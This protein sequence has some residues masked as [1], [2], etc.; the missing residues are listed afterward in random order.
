GGHGDT[1][2]P[3]AVPDGLG[4][5]PLPDAN[6]TEVRCVHGGSISSVDDPVPGVRGLCFV[7]VTFTAAIVLD[8]SRFYSPQH[9]LNITLLQCVLMGLS[10]RGIGARVHVNVVF[11]MLDSGDLEFRG[12]FGASSQLLVAGCRL[13]SRSGCAIYFP[14]FSFG[15]NSTLQLLGNLIEG[16]N[17]AV[18]FV[19]TVV[20]DGG[21]IV[22]KGNTL[23]I[24]DEDDGM[25]SALCFNAVDVKNDG[26]FDVENNTMNAANGICFYEDTVVSSAGL[27]R[28]ADCNFAGSTEGF[29]SAL[30]SFDGWVTLES[31]AQWRVEG[32]SVS[33]ASVLI[34]SHSQYNF[35][36]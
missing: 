7:N 5:L 13:L 32:N 25:E 8:L 1:C 28:V 10:I 35:S 36:C 3:A 24:T 11:S 14:H 9:T 16:K 23:S 22:V 15:A 17:Y 34:I 12:D 21:G 30:V 19:H 29:K 26:Y 33:A 27:L 18:H 6:D 4:P 31:G 20:V 2:L